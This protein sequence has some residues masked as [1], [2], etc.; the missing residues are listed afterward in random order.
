ME[1][2]SSDISSSI[3]NQP[4]EI[5]SQLQSTMKPKDEI[6]LGIDFGTSNSCVSFWHSDKNRVK[7][8]KNVLSNCKLLIFAFFLFMKAF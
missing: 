5:F 4:N 3:W 2:I 8:V 1:E 7:I 6:I